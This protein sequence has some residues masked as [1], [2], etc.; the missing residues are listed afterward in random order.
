MVGLPFQDSLRPPDGSA[1][2]LQVVVLHER[3]DL[4]ERDLGADVVG[5]LVVGIL[6]RLHDVVRLPSAG[7]LRGRSAWV[8]CTRPDRRT[9][10]P[11]L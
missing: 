10:G 7:R 9:P 1:C 2:S 6:E 3:P 8:G 4:L 11:L 5:E